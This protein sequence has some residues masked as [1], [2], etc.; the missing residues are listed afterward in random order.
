MRSKTLS[1]I[2]SGLDSADI[3]SKFI[4]K[5]SDDVATFALLNKMVLEVDYR[6]RSFE[7]N[8]SVIDASATFRFFI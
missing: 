5:S 7:V 4:A 3:C 6:G 2:Y 1:A 8:Q